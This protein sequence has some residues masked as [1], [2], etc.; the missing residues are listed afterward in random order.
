MLQGS[1]QGYEHAY[2]L[3]RGHTFV[4]GKLTP[5]CGNT[6][7]MVGEDGVSWLAKHFEEGRWCP[8]QAPAMSH[9][10]MCSSVHV[11]LGLPPRMC[12][13]VYQG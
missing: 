11:G 6:A 13:V 10:T 5:V 9:K 3:D 7:A 4:T 8:M 2:Q 12:A 1:I